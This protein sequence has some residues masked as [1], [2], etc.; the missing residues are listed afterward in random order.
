MFIRWK[1]FFKKGIPARS[2]YCVV[3]EARYNLGDVQ[4]NLE[5]IK[6]AL[7]QAS[8]VSNLV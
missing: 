7:T 1:F 8:R 3:E 2:L 5:S 6:V 4:F